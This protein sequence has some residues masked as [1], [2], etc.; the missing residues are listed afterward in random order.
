ML[1]IGFTGVRHSGK[2]TAAGYS[3]LLFETSGVQGGRVIVTG[4]AAAMKRV[5]HKV[6][7]LMLPPQF[8]LPDNVWTDQA[9]KEGFDLWN[10]QGAGQLLPRTVMQKLGTDIMRAELPDIWIQILQREVLNLASKNSQGVALLTDVRFENENQC[11]KNLGMRA[12]ISTAVV[13]VKPFYSGYTPPSVEHGSHASETEMEKI[14]P[15]VTLY[16]V[17]FP[18]LYDQVARMTA[19]MADRGP[20]G[21][22]GEKIMEAHEKLKAKAK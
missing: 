17:N 10:G 2:D 21:C 12:G 20:S 1:V 9:L 18:E 22:D 16:N 3:K 8:P 14:E 5:C 4:F 19:M 15:T 7:Q 6:A 11:V 13:R